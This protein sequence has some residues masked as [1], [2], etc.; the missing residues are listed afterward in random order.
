MGDDFLKQFDDMVGKK[1]RRL[2]RADY[3]TTRRNYK[4][5]ETTGT[6]DPLYKRGLE[7]KQDYISQMHFL[8]QG[9][10][11]PAS[12]N[13]LS[14]AYRLMRTNEPSKI[15]LG[16]KLYAFAGRDPNK[17]NKK[18]LGNLNRALKSGVL[19][20]DDKKEIRGFLKGG[21]NYGHMNRDDNDD[22]S[23]LAKKLSVIVLL[24]GAIGLLSFFYSSMTGNVIGTSSNSSSWIISVLLTL[25]LLI[26]FFLIKK[27]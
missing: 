2:L 21:G 1:Q 24:S 9:E 23:G 12:N 22:N 27:R 5:V 17:I 20:E 15:L 6:R 3:R 11:L 8:K 4:E 16:A 10:D 18:L 14:I 19:T 13:N 25:G 7:I 26:I